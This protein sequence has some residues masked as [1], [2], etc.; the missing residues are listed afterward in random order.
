MLNKYIY[1]HEGSVSNIDTLTAKY[2]R[3][4]FSKLIICIINDRHKLCN[5]QTNY[6]RMM[7]KIVFFSVL[8]M[9]L[10]VK[11]MQPKMLIIGT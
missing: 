7:K 5:F 4:R 8:N 1:F 2:W 10:K 3:I 9:K 6:Q 11:K